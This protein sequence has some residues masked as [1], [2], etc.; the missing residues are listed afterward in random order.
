MGQ[1]QDRM[2]ADLQ[3]RGLSPHTR[4][5]YL[6]CMRRFLMD[7]R[8]PADQVTLEDIRQYQI[9]LVRE[10]KISSSKF[11]QIVSA[12]RFFYRVTLR[13]DWNIDHIPYQKTERRLP[14]I[15]STEKIAALLGSLTN[16]KHRAI[17][18]TLYS[19]GLRVSE[20]VH[21]KVSDIDSQR[22]VLRIEQGKGR[23]DRYV[24][25]SPRLLKALREYWNAY[26]PRTWLFPG[27]PSDKPMAQRS[28]CRIVKKAQQAADL[29][30]RFYPHLLRHSFATHLLENGTHICVI[31][32]L[33][34]HRSLKSTQIY[35]Q[36]AQN[37]LQETPSPLD[38]LPEPARAPLSQKNSLVTV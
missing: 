14:Q 4:R 24:M 7:V 35:A 8:R 13:K 36:V 29:P 9:R 38:S 3:I 20:A 32:K 28:L 31:Q 11:N 5:V 6:A 16:L 25:L 10:S 12:V 22:M 30:G 18:M 2:D 27:R 34:G 1:F 17:L 15:P 21:L 37:F 33:L 19:G 26:H 23:K